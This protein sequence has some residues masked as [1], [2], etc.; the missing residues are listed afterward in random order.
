MISTCYPW[1]L[2]HPGTGFTT[3]RLVQELHVCTGDDCLIAFYT[4]AE[5]SKKHNSID[6]FMDLTPLYDDVISDVILKSLKELYQ[7]RFTLHTGLFDINTVDPIP[8]PRQNERRLTND[9]IPID[10]KQWRVPFS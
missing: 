8:K 6:S 9:K 1:V 5:I 3:G 2:V 10:L 7:R 4:L